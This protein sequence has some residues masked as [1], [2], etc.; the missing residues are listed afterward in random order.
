[1]SDAKPAAKA[2]ETQCNRC[3]SPVESCAAINCPQIDRSVEGPKV[4]YARCDDC[5]AEFTEEDSDPSE[6]S[7]FYERIANAPGCMIP[8]GQ[9]TCGA[10][11]YPI[12]A[13][14]SVELNGAGVGFIAG[15][16]RKLLTRHLPAAKTTIDRYMQPEILAAFADKFNAR[17]RKRLE[18]AVEP[19]ST[20]NQGKRS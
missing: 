6:I 20:T 1:M 14:E 13:L 9:C 15:E 11:T 3:G 12:E 4:P 8:A 18:S 17:L 19:A 2:P 7:D 5:A 10:L 16:L